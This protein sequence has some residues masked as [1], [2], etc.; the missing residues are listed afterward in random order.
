MQA[1]IST[2]LLTQALQPVLEVQSSE[3]RVT[4][5]AESLQ[6]IA[7]ERTQKAAEEARHKAEEK[8]RE[9]AVRKKQEEEDEYA[10]RQLVLAIQKGKETITSDKGPRT[11][12]LEEEDSYSADLSCDEE[13]ARKIA[14]MAEMQEG[15]QAEQHMISRRKRQ[16]LNPSL[17]NPED[18]GVKEA[19][20]TSRAQYLS[21]LIKSLNEENKKILGVQTPYMK[22]FMKVILRRT[23]SL[24][25]AQK[26]LTPVRDQENQKAETTLQ[27][28]QVALVVVDKKNVVLEEIMDP[29]NRFLHTLQV[30]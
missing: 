21:D 5:F 19:L 16:L 4:N 9:D 2:Q 12:G 18:I 22:E 1:K 14:L 13:S 17:P 6:H 8:T 7:Q 26:D 29:V 28:A 23:A 25:L 3:Q 15:G 30:D 11:A 24:V 20:G 10:Q 27:I